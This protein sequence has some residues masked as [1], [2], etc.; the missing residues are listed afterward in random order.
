MVHKLKLLLTGVLAAFALVGFAQTKT[1]QGKVVDDMNQPLPG[2]AVMVTGTQTGTVTDFEG[3]YS[4][5]ADNAA[6]E[7]TFSFIGFKSQSVAITGN[8]VDCTMQPDFTELDEIVAVGYGVQ[9]K[10]L[11]TGATVNV[12]GEDIQK[13]NTTNAM[14]ALYSQVPG[15]TITQNNGQPWSDYKITIRGLNT[16]GSSG[17]LYVI[18]GIAGGDIQSLNPAD[19]ESIDVLKDAASAAIYGARAAGGVV[20]VTTRQGQKGNIR[21]SYDGYYSIQKANLNGVESVSANEYIKLVD[22]AFTSNGAKFQGPEHYEDYQALMPVQYAQIKSGAF[23]GTDWL[24]ESINDNA[25]SYNHAIGISGGNDLARF[26]AGFSK[27]SV[28]GTLGY[29][30]Q[31]FFN[32]TTIRL[33]TDFTLWSKGGRDILKIGENATLSKFNS[34]GVSVGNIY[35]NTIHTALTYTPLLPAY[36]ADGSFYTYEDQVKDGWQQKDG[37]YN[38]LQEYGLS[39]SENNNFRLHGNAWLEFQPLEDWKFRSVYGYRFSSSGFRSY[40]PEYKLSGTQQND[41]DDVEQNMRIRN[42]WSWENTLAWK[43]KF[44]PHNVDALVGTSIEGTGWGQYVRGTRQQTKF[45]KWESANLGACESDINSEMV[46]IDGSNTI[47]FNNLVSF[48]GRAN[49][50]FGETYMATVILRADGSSNFAKGKRWGIFPSV[51]AGWIISNESFMTGTASWLEYLKLRGSWGQNGNCSIRNF[52]YAATIALD[53]PYD[54]TSDNMSSS[55]GAYPDIL[56]NPEL[57]WETTEQLDLGFDA[58]FFAGRLGMTFDWYRK[59]TKDWLVDAPSL[60]IYGTGAPTINGGAVRNQGFE[61]GLTWNDRLGD[62]RYTVAANL[63]KNTNEVL[64][65]DNADGILHGATN[66]IAQNIESYNTYEARPGK[67]IGYFTGIASEGIFQNQKQIDEYLNNGYVSI[68]GYSKESVGDSSKDGIAIKPGDVIWV[69][70]NGDGVYDDDDVVEIGNPHPDFTLGVNVNLE[71]KGFDLAVSASGAFGQQVLQSYRS[72]ANSDFE[73]YTNNFVDRLW[74]GDG[75]TDKFPRFTYGK[76]NNFYCKGY[77]GDIWVQNA[78]Y[79]KIRTITFG[80]DFKK[81]FTQLPLNQLRLYF[82]GQNLL[83]FTGYD[84]MD[85]EVGYGADH[86][87]ASGIDI[88]FYPS[89]KAYQFGLS[90]KF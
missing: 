2:V 41:Y 32:R 29:P 79:L 31:T 38:L 33:N 64:Y 62:F 80:Y 19:I 70:Q 47:P 54:F 66:V 72:F 76:H 81:L 49:Y 71:Y 83:C 60:K 39:E 16:T 23:T 17:P 58:H 9:K 21:V 61:L 51:S 75:S 5:A 57:T 25:P 27:S 50:N 74:T 69:D 67:A 90:V 89:P 73:N 36:K 12:S 7:L 88:G 14:G 84:G 44:G 26:S 3:N 1:L 10:K 87:W 45:G 6:S 37:A 4:L 59:D 42:S 56:P 22:D 86:D 13:Q 11:L 77:V 52:Q 82:T 65:I 18:D 85:P 34:R 30:N 55:T 53:A 63:A 40:T 78:D 15:V 24:K 43:H 68:D 8:T 28:E 46:G 35:N 20:L 48:F